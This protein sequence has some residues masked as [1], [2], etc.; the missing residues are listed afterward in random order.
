MKKP[1]STELS[2]EI[3]KITRSIE[4]VVTGD[5]LPTVVMLLTNADLKLVT[6][7]N[8]WLFNWKLEL[9][10]EE[11]RVY[12]LTIAG[13]PTI[14]QGLVS[15]ELRNDHV[16]MHLVEN[17]PFNLG[18]NKVYA[19][20]MGNLVAFGCKLAFENGHQGNLAF[21]SKTALMQHYHETLGGEHVGGLRMVI[22][23]PAALHL[24]NKYFPA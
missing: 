19:G 17:A 5:S 7:K 1:R 2:F 23:T 15:L 18:R 21:D 24:V 6:R 4:N 14:I 12:K 16:Y 22:D 11:R 20:V 8:G 3:D 10:V 13:N 9:L